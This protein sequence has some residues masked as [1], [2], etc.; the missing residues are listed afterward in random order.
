MSLTT[1]HPSK[2]QLVLIVIAV[3]VA[4][5]ILLLIGNFYG[6]FLKTQVAAPSTTYSA[7]GDLK[8]E[9]LDP[10]VYTLQ[11]TGRNASTSVNSSTTFEV[12]ST[13]GETPTA[14]SSVLPY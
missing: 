6:T 8:T 13:S 4:F 14:S 1:F 11:F 7:A 9:T 5:I 12:T 3:I 10:G 2:K